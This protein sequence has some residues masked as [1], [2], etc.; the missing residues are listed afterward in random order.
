MRDGEC[1]LGIAPWSGSVGQNGLRLCADGRGAQCNDKACQ[2]D[3]PCTG[4]SKRERQISAYHSSE[5]ADAQ[6]LNRWLG[7]HIPVSDRN[8]TGL[9]DI[10]A[11]SSDRLGTD[12]KLLLIT[13]RKWWV[14]A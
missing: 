14:S 10:V 7:G 11:K 8:V 13:T 2:N 12:A 6:W 5:P 3:A 9:N 1:P 4:S